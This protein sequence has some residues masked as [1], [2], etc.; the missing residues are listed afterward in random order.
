MLLKFG[1]I[2]TEGSGSLG[3]HTIQKSHGGVQ[4]RSKPIPRGIPSNSQVSIRSINPVLQAGWQSLT[5]AQQKIWNDWPVTHGIF[6][7]KGDK[8]P[9]SGHSLWMKWQFDRLYNN[10]PFI[11]GPDK[12]L[13]SYFGPELVT[14]G[15]FSS[16]A[17]WNIIGTAFSIAAGKLTGVNAIGSD[18]IYRAVP[19]VTGNYY[20]FTILTDSLT[21]GTY[22]LYCGTAP[23]TISAAGLITFDDQVIYPDHY[24]YIQGHTLFTGVIDFV[25]VK[26]ILN[27]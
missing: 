6:N 9:L 17:G 2:I 16:S 12:Y 1:A 25:S 8:H 15:D 21:T 23:H 7:V 10:L 20:R 24:I 27:Y 3:G 5:P 11:S 22:Y 19:V 26:Q 18:F 14:N 4:L 13:P